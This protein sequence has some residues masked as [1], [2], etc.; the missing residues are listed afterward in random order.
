MSV[1]ISL[2][3]LLSHTHPWPYWIERRLVNLSGRFFFIINIYQFISWCNFDWIN[4]H[5]TS[6]SLCNNWYHH[7]NEDFNMKQLELF[8]T[9]MFWGAVNMSGNLCSWCLTCPYASVNYFSFFLFPMSFLCRLMFF[10][11]QL[12]TNG[13]LSDLSNMHIHARHTHTHKTH[14]R[15]EKKKE[16]IPEIT[17][18][19]SVHSE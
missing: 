18:S 11:E 19:R 5:K 12:S 2:F 15:I 6:S 4:I 16:R 3:W 7:H 13:F 1:S 9:E 17:P 8:F 10:S 14:N